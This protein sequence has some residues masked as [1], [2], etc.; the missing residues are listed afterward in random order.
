MFTLKKKTTTNWQWSSK[1]TDLLSCRIHRLCMR[2]GETNDKKKSQP[3]QRHCCTWAGVVLFV[4][5]KNTFRRWGGG[6]QEEGERLQKTVM[7]RLSH[8]ELRNSRWNECCVANVSVFS[9]VFCLDTLL[10]VSGYQRR[11]VCSL[12]V[13]TLLSLTISCSCW[14]TC[15]LDSSLP[16]VCHVD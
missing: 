8:P 3:A 9:G 4:G 1:H 2:L 7:S 16:L 5:D 11:T 14:V 6:E 13:F 10:P 15:R 12:F